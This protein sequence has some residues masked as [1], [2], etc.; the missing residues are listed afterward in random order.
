MLCIAAVQPVMYKLQVMLQFLSSV[1]VVSDMV[2]GT[3]RA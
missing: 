3:S 2:A 1:G